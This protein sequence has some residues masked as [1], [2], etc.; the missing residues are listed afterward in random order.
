MSARVIRWRLAVG[1][2]PLEVPL[3]RYVAVASREMDTVDVWT[4]DL[5]PVTA[6]LVVVGTGH[7]YDSTRWSPIGTAVAPGG[8][9]VW[10]VLR[11]HGDVS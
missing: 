1:A 7:A 8:R 9:L 11:H 10:H 5:E 4:D 6:R 3:G 2:P